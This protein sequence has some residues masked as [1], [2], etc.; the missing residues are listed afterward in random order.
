VIALTL[1]EFDKLKCD[2]Q[3]HRNELH[4][5]LIAIMG[6]RITARIKGLDA[7]RWELPQAKPGADY[8][9]GLLVKETV[10]MLSM[11]PC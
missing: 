1:I 7:I 2:Y 5:E 8:Y 10:K 9:M 11:L 6:D 4:A 3:E